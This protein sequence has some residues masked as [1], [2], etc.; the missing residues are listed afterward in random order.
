MFYENLNDEQIK[1]LLQQRPLAVA[2][3]AG[4][5]FDYYSPS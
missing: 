4:R 1:I 3:C 2:V 5:D